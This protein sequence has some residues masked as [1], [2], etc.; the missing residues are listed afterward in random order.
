[1]QNGNTQAKTKTNRLV[2]STATTYAS[3][4]LMENGT[5]GKPWLWSILELYRSMG[6]SIFRR[7]EA[8][9]PTV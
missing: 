5:S 8:R 2:T 4:K 7:P 1:M 3:P 9:S 6:R